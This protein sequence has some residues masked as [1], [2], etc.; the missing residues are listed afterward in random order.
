MTDFIQR[1]RRRVSIID[2]V[3][4]T[5]RRVARALTINGVATVPACNGSRAR[6]HVP[7]S[8]LMNCTRYDIRYEKLYIGW[9][10]RNF[11]ASHLVG[12]TLSNV[13]HCDIAEIRFVG[14]LMIIRTFFFINKR[15]EF[16]LGLYNTINLRPLTPRIMLRYT[17]KMAIVSWP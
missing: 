6:I 9:Q 4:A 8:M 17:H 14:K 16:Y 15:I 3:A 7:V 2:C 12:K 5:K 13:F 1:R 10:W 11:D